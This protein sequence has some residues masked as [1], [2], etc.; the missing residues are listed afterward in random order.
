M[1][2]GRDNY[3]DILEVRAKRFYE[4]QPSLAG[5]I[6]QKRLARALCPALTPAWDHFH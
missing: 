2:D 3:A 5:L 4:G 6:P 1:E